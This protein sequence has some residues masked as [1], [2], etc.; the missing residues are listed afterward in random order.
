MLWA[1][2]FALMRK[3]GWGTRAVLD[4]ILMVLIF[5]IRHGHEEFTSTTA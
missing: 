5:W 4:Y 3:A 2:A 1:W